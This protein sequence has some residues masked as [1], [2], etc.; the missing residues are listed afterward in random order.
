MGE[1]PALQRIGISDRDVPADEGA[2][3]A[4][5]GGRDRRRSKAM[6]VCQSCKE[7]TEVPGSCCGAGV[8]VN[9]WILC[10]EDFAETE[11]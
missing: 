4:G 5:H 2:T 6:G 9:G 11:G 8:Y 3:R 1:M 7:W 10:D